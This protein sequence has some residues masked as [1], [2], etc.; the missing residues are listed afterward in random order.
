MSWYPLGRPIGTT[1]YPG[2]QFTAVYIKNYIMKSM[3]LNDVCCYIP[4]WFGVLTSFVTA[5]IAYECSIPANTSSSILGFVRDAW[6]GEKTMPTNSN[7]GNT[8]L[9]F[10]WYSPALQCSIFCMGSMAIVPAHLMRSMGG[11]YD[12]ESIAI[13]AMVTTFYCWVRSLRS[14]TTNSDSDSDTTDTE[15][16]D[17]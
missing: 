6:K 7:Y 8:R 9:L 2:M 11:G 3:S 15:D 4:V 12:N 1:I 10:G 17:Y 14:T 16:E 13:F 5:A